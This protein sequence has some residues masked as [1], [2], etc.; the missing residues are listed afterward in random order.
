M[1]PPAST[2]VL[3]KIEKNAI[4][5]VIN[6]YLLTRMSFSAFKIV[7]ILHPVFKISKMLLLASKI[8]KIKPT[9]FKIE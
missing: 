2:L 5:V 9:T 4:F 1:V 3:L 6:K 8:D 7:E